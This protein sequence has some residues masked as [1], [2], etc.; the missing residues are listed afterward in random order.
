[1]RSS[2]RFFPILV[3]VCILALAFSHAHA[4]VTTCVSVIDD[5]PQANIIGCHSRIS[6]D[7]RFVAFHSDAPNLAPGDNNNLSDVFVCDR[8]T[9]VTERVSVP[10]RWRAGEQHQL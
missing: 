9:G 8:Q 3:C 2:G 4:G 1:M 7:G 5:G 6:A 10:E